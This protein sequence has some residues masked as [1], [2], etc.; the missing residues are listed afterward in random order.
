MNPQI[1]IPH[2]YCSDW[3]NKPIYFSQETPIRIP[4]G[5]S[6]H[7]QSVF[8]KD[9]I[10]FTEVCRGLR[11]PARNGET[12]SDKKQEAIS[13]FRPERTTGGEG[14][15]GAC[16]CCGW[17]GGLFHLLA[18]CRNSDAAQKT[19]AHT[20]TGWGVMPRMFSHLNC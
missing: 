18:D 12:L 6:W 9:N 19:G 14:V 8:Q 11:G 15:P 4:V 17:T 5:N 1:K 10:L 2:L 3:K 7:T 20:H 16:E 13:T